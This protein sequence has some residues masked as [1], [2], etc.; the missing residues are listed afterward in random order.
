MANVLIRARVEVSKPTPNKITATNWKQYLDVVDIDTGKV[1]TKE[2]DSP[3]HV[4][5]AFKNG[6]DLHKIPYNKKTAKGKEFYYSFD[7]SKS[8]KKVSTVANAESIAEA[9][10][11]DEIS[12]QVAEKIAEMKADTS[13]S[14]MDLVATTEGSEI[15]GFGSH[16]EAVAFIQQSMSLKPKALIIPNTK[17]KFLVRS[18]VRGKNIMMTGPAGTGKTL[19]AMSVAKVLK[20]PFFYFNLGA[21][22]DP[23]ATLIGNTHL[24]KETGTFFA[25]SPFIKAIRTV[26]AV[27]L[28]D[29]FSRS[30]PEAWNIL[31]TVV[32]ANQRYIRLDEK[33]DAE[34]VQVAV[35]VSFIATANIGAE[36]TSTRIIDRAMFE[37]FIPIEMEYLTAEQEDGLLQLLFPDLNRSAISA[38]SDIAD[39]TRKKLL[40]GD[41]SMST[42]MSTRTSIEVASAMYD[43]F[44]LAEACEACVYSLFSNDGGVN[45]ERTIVKQIVQSKVDQFGDTVGSTTPEVPFGEEFTS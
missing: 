30:H 14:V 3:Y 32:D 15:P 40:S 43:G 38:I 39:Q 29:E 6:W 41:G 37:R 31:M 7:K 17:W 25:E 42:C 11:S 35:G 9:K 5:T 2:F 12:N 16:T 1:V 34:L 10:V 13:K 18:V 27:V 19:A 28:L 33:D 23:R 20:R 44:S 45:S 36:Y 21:T 4:V 8:K 24:N 26:G 22:Q